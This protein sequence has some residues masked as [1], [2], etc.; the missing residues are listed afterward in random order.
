[1]N[2]AG[3]R[4]RRS[5]R[6]CA[7]MPRCS[8]RNP[9]AG[10]AAVALL[11]LQSEELSLLRVQKRCNQE[12]TTPRLAL[13]WHRATAPVLPQLRHPC[14][15]RATRPVDHDSPPHRGSRV[16]PRAIL[17]RIRC[18]TVAR[19]RELES[20]GAQ[21]SIENVV[22]RCYEVLLSAKRAGRARTI[23]TAG[24]VCCKNP[25]PV[26]TTPVCRGLFWNGY[27]CCVLRIA[28]AR[29]GAA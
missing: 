19:L 6:S 21:H 15:C 2:L 10:D 11:R 12:K 23:A 20:R 27:G 29:A 17:A 22:L 28:V 9:L 1:M 13:A 8:C 26:K 4:S 16:E 14:R 5:N 7:R 3:M 24:W 25:D 18:A